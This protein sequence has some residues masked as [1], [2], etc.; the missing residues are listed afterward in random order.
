[1][2]CCPKTR[3]KSIVTS[4]WIYKIKHAA[5]GN[6]DKHKAIFVALGFSQKEGLDYEENFAPVSRYTSIISILA[7]ATV[8]KWKIHQMD[9]KTSF[10]NGV[11]EEEVYV[12]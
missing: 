12:E 8:M 1:M 10:L 9:V 3:R 6:I 5:D 7:L 2:G 4:K 11:V